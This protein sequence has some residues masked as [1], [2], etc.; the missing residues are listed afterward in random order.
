MLVPLLGTTL[1]LMTISTPWNRWACPVRI[2]VTASFMF[3]SGRFLSAAEVQPADVHLHVYLVR[4]ELE[5]L[6]WYLGRP[7]NRQDDIRVSDVAPREVYFQALTL[8]RKADRL[9]FEQI[10]ERRLPP[11][12]PAGQ[13]RPADVY[14]MVDA[15][16]RR[17]RAV[18]T[19]LQ[20]SR[21][22]QGM[23]RDP[24]KTP[25]D[26]FRSIVQA[27][28]QL[29]LLLDQRVS[30]S[31]VYQQVT[32]CIGYASSLLA[33]ASTKERLPAA[34]EF[35]PGKMPRDVYGR[36]LE[37]FKLVSRIGER[38]GVKMLA[39]SEE[40]ATESVTPSDV[41]D[42][43]SL[44]VSELK[45]LHD[46]FPDPPPPRPAYRVGRKVPA[47]VFQRAGM[48]QRQLTELSRRSPTK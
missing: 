43:A 17:V 23:T 8:Y 18:K 24:S 16:L 25:T 6:R 39:L 11:E 34:P 15:A 22:V 32:V 19:H 41:F 27:N 44:L 7:K 28:R 5:H 46:N 29:N 35:V 37:C 45:H 13:L 48:L 1:R 12:T 36:L 14:K 2:A 33:T 20:V 40:A 30:P 9:A 31:E 42:I 4:E 10:R 38:Q 21:S 3:F 47:H 26:V